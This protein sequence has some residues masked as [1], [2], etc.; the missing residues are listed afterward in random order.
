MAPVQLGG[1]PIV[2]PGAPGQVAEPLAIALATDN[3]VVAGARF[4]GTVGWV[5]RT[6]DGQVQA[7]VTDGD[8]LEAFGMRW[9]GRGPWVYNMD[10][11]H[12]VELKDGPPR[13]IAVQKIKG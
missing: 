10:G 9:E 7:C 12:T 5:R 13:A 3:E 8:L 1:P 4:R 6:T 2:V 11:K